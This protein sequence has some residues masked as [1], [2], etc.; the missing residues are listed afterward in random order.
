MATLGLPV[1]D[2]AA[3]LFVV[4]VG[5]GGAAR[6]TTLSLRLITA[7]GAPWYALFLPVLGSPVLEPHLDT[8]TQGVRFRSK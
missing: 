3:I 2:E 8:A 7:G 5:R 6:G 1:C 4:T